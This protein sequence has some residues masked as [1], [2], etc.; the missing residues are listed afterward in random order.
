MNMTRN[1]FALTAVRDLIKKFPTYVPLERIFEEVR[2]RRKGIG[3]G[4]L[5][6]PTGIRKREG[7]DAPVISPFQSTIKRTVDFYNRAAKQAVID[8]L[9][10][11]ALTTQGGGRIA[12]EIP[13]RKGELLKSFSGKPEAWSI[14]E[15]KRKLFAFGV[16][17][18]GSHPFGSGFALMIFAG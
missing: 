5:N 2:P 3:K 15:G 17:S 7:I 1:I 14:R 8:A 11:K 13:A 9:L 18:F 6:L 4:L 16:P 12:E 10:D